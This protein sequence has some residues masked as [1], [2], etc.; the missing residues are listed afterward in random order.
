[1]KR[2]VTLERSHPDFLNYLWGRFSAKERALPLNSLNVRTD[3]ETV[4]F[5]I[6]SLSDLKKPNWLRIWLKALRPRSYLQVLVPLFLLLTWSI[7]RGAS[8]DPDT[9][10]LATLAVTFLQAAILLRNDVEDHISGVDRVR[11]DRGSR[12]IQNGWLTA[13]S[14]QNASML[15]L[16]LSFLCALPLVFAFPNLLLVLLATIVFGG[17]A[18][19]RPGGSYRDLPAGEF[20]L[21]LLGG[22]LL[23]VGFQISMGAAVTWWTIG[24]G[25]LW[26]WLLLFPVHLRDLE[27]LIVEGQ[28]GRGSPLGHLGFDRGIYFIRWWWLLGVT[29]FIIYHALDNAPLGFWFFLFLFIL[30]CGRFFKN[31]GDLKSPAGSQ[32]LQVRKQGD[33]LFH[34]LILLW[35]MES[36]WRMRP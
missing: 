12:A 1:M 32:V 13:T 5:Q 34:T 30:V 2:L 16:F 35:V 27:N 28:G 36:F 4:T 31:L 11:T 6:L 8:L 33:F 24:L 22:P 10:W 3:R 25:A 7:A 14:L 9:T 21:F 20:L 19:F 23:A 26:G 18:F 17:L 15:F 29:G